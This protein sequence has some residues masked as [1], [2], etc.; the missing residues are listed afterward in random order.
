MVVEQPV[1][2]W[3]NAPAQPVLA[4]DQL[5][6]WRV[7]LAAHSVVVETLA[8]SLSPDERVRVGCLV[9]E[10][11]RTRFVVA[12]GMLRRI[13]AA[14][15]HRDPS[16]IAFSYNDYG[17]PAL[18]E[19]LAGEQLS[20]NVAHS[21]EIAL[22]ALVIGRQVGVDIERIRDDLAITAML[23]GIFTAREQAILTALPI[24][25]QRR[26]FFRGW[27]CKEAYLKARGEGLAYAPDR[28]EVSLLA[29][30]SPRLLLSPDA[31]A[32]RWILRTI[33]V[34][35]GYAAAVVVERAIGATQCFTAEHPHG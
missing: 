21:G 5:H 24:E 10:R 19:P 29:Q 30:E 15:L 25:Q 22:V 33:D 7:G 17:K 16:A 6:L 32:R 18:A 12:R 28:F 8:Q 27:A 14:Y 20:F 13:L 9:F 31:D 26:A 3:K 4:I 11:D 23:S 35:T 1:I 34:G 2:E